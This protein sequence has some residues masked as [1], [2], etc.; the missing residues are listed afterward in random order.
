MPSRRVWCLMIALGVFGRNACGQ[1]TLEPSANDAPRPAA[2]PPLAPPVEKI[3]SPIT[4]HFALR[5][6]FFAPKITTDLRLDPPGGAGLGTPLNAEQQLGLDSKPY[7][8]R[9]EVYFRLRE[10]NRLRVDFYQVNRSAEKALGETVV[11]GKNI[12]LDETP[13]SSEFDWQM[14]SFTYTYSFI[15]NDRVEL[16]AGLGLTLIQARV[17]AAEPYTPLRTDETGVGAVPT[18]ALDATWRISRRFAAT[19]R[20]QYFGASVSHVKGQFGDYHGDLQFRA[21]PNVAFGLGYSDFNA[22]LQNEGG[23]DSLVGRFSLK[24]AGPE[25]FAR[26][27][28]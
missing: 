17:S 9:F 21:L 15:R 12:F 4:D 28:F 1:T 8:G 26:V 20:G 27:S 11:L 6:S 22:L 25:A 18:L 23:S 7:Q 14:F 16:G 3:P 10:R 13:L 19:L 5:A 24:V 2:T